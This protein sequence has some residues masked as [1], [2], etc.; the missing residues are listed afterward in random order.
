MSRYLISILL[1]CLA[2]SLPVGAI[3]KGSGGMGMS[4]SPAFSDVDTNQNGLITEQ[5]F[6]HFQKTRQKERAS[7]GRI[8]KNAYDNDGMFEQIDLDHNGSIDANEFQAH[9]GTMRQ[10]K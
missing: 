2:I 3:A 7:D 10:S 6:K 1:G 5:E 8:L 4:Q 9:R